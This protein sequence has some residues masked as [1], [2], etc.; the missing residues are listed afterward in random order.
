MGCEPL[1]EVEVSF[2][3]F[4]GDRCW[5]FVREG[6]TESRFPWLTIRERADMSQY[7]PSFA[8]PADPK[9]S[10]VLVRT[11][12]GAVLDVIDAVLARKLWPPGA[13]V[14]RQHRGIFDAFP[15]SLITAASIGSLGT[16]L[17]GLLDV[18][19]FR[20]NIL[21]ETVEESA[22]AE[23]G[24]VGRVLRIGGMRMRV[25]E[26]DARCAVITIDPATAEREPGVLRAVAQERD[27]CMGVYGSTVQP[28]RIRLGDPVLI[29]P[30]S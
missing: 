1:T 25:D 20:P 14:M 29:E 17:G 2:Q 26:R 10:T 9:R 13:H 23:D 6:L 27:G 19:R 7:L 24:W 18:Q 12:S 5:A 22:F 4:A 3:G 8:D 15:L 30:E 21:V 11:P 16:M 28:G